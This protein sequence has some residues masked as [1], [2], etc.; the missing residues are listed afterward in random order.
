MPPTVAAIVI[1]YNGREVVKACIDSLLAQSRLPDEVFLIDN[2]S[3]DDTP[4]RVRAWF[5]SVHV[6]RNERNLGFP[7]A[8]NVGIRRSRSDLV[9]ILNNDIVVEPTWLE[10]LLNHTSEPWSFWASRVV[11]TDRPEIIDSAGDGMAVIGAAFKIGHGRTFLHY[12]QNR[13]VF[14]PSAAAALYRR[15]LL[16]ETEGFDEDFFLIYEDADL[17]LRARL[18]GHRCLYVADAVVRHRI[19]LSIRRFSKNYVYYGHRN[20][21][22]VFWKNFPTRLL[23]QYLPERLFFNALCLAYFAGHGRAGTFLRAKRDAFR[24]RDMIRSKRRQ[25]LSAARISPAELRHG[26]TRNW[27]RH[28]WKGW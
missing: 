11:R 2:A 17:N 8:C 21:E 25:V 23:L 14:G 12:Q 19:N 4:E 27:L 13:E 22:L 28:R 5:P 7:A 1:N 24:Q 20:S 10:N 6:I 18:L 16:E 9:A 15:E 3:E 26:L